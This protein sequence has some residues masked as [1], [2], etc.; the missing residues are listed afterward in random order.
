RL[1]GR[2]AGQFRPGGARERGQFRD[3]PAAVSNRDSQGGSMSIQKI[4]SGL[5]A[6]RAAREALY[7]HFHRHPELSLQ[8]DRTAARIAEELAAAGIDTVLRIG[9]TGLVAVL[10]NGDGPIVAMRGDIDALPMAERSGVDYA[11]DGVTQVD[12]ATGRETP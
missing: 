2:R 5:D 6:S 7:R 10:E 11:A 1:R 8:E 4:L 9:R 3:P 12:E